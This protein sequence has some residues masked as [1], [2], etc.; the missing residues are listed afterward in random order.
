MDF[1]Y[2]KETLDTLVS[3]RETPGVDCS[4]YM[5]HKEVFRYFAGM[6]DEKNNTKLSGDEL[7]IIYSM[8]KMLTCVSALQ[9]FEKGAFS[10]D[11]PLSKYMGE[12]SK[13]R[14]YSHFDGEQNDAVETGQ[15]LHAKDNA[16]SV[17]E[18]KNAITIRHLFTMSAG[19][20]YCLDEEPV[21]RTIAAGKTGTADVMRALS[22]TVLGFEPGTR[23]RYSL[24]HDV[25]GALV[26]I[27][28]GMKLGEYMRKYIFTPLGMQDT[29][30]GVPE[31]CGRRLRLAT[32]YMKAGK[33]QYKEIPPICEF[34][35][36]DDYESGGA[37][38]ISSTADYAVFMDALA[39]GGIGK[40]GKRIL[41][42]DTVELMRCNQLTGKAFED[43]E[44]PRRG[45]GYGF[46]VRTHMC[47][48]ISG[49]PSPAGEFGW[50]GAAG[51]FSLADP[52]NKLSLTYFQH[53]RGWDLNMGEILRNALYRSLQSG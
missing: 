27:W 26:E 17:C 38:L 46:G 9:L 41:S 18:A 32:L 15:I 14:V 29:F 3:N 43:F 7:Y 21:V 11:D 16:I 44:L 5:D 22:E 12:F 48:E 23:Y 10:M 42:S 24:C 50:G 36:T 51:A 20:D 35:F 31:E 39:C 25:L 1:Q 2:L 13:M 34:N 52:E 53:M 45:Y 49:S 40:T 37:G 8:T 33:G 4:V 47:P 6:K 19:F 30:F 28:S